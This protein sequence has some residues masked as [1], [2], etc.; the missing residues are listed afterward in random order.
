MLYNW[1]RKNIEF[2]PQHHLKIKKIDL[3]QGLEK[4]INDVNSFNNHINNIK[5]MVNYCKDKNNE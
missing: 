4:K 3:G 1:T 2:I 5:E